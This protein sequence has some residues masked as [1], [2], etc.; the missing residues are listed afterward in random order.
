[1]SQNVGSTKTK[2]PRCGA[3]PTI[4]KSG[5][6]VNLGDQHKIGINYVRNRIRDASCICQVSSKSHGWTTPGF[7]DTAA[8]D[9]CC[10]RDC[11]LINLQPATAPLGKPENI[12]SSLL[13]IQCNVAYHGVQHGARGV[14]TDA[15]S[16]AGASGLRG[17]IRNRPHL[18]ILRRG[19]L[20]HGFVT[21]CLAKRGQRDASSQRCEERDARNCGGT[22]GT[23]ATAGS[24]GRLEPVAWVLVPPTVEA[25]QETLRRRLPS[26]EEGQLPL[27]ACK[28]KQSKAKQSKAKQSKAKQSKAKQR[29]PAGDS[30]GFTACAGRTS[31]VKNRQLADPEGPLRHFLT[32]CPVDKQKRMTPSLWEKMKDHPARPEVPVRVRARRRRA[33]EVV[34]DVAGAHLDPIINDVQGFCV[35]TRMQGQS[36]NCHYTRH[37]ATY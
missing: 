27:R 8:R 19:A 25:L 36:C 13:Q 10:I 14:L 21:R 29:P 26:T 16:A 28:A 1:M 12:G 15:V 20:V 22:T 5:D 34:R 17:R 35:R 33:H 37:T 3:T 11:H 18:Q 7:S 9:T 2:E 30:G 6:P 4:F 32:D 24:F 23:M 31:Q